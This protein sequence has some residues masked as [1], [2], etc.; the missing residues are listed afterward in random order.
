[1]MSET[2]CVF[3]EKYCLGEANDIVEFILG[4]LRKSKVR[5][6]PVS[7]YARASVACRHCSLELVSGK[8]V[9]IPLSLGGG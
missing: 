2:C 4:V 5:I 6:V 8:I 1:M 9:E 3:I 7:R